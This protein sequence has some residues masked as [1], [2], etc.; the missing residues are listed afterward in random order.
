MVKK[1]TKLS[2]VCIHHVLTQPRTK[3]RNILLVN[4]DQKFESGFS[5]VAPFMLC[6]ISLQRNSFK[7][8]KC[9]FVFVFVEIQSCLKFELLFVHISDIAQKCPKTKTNWISDI[10]RPNICLKT[11]PI[12][13]IS[14][15][16]W[17]LNCLNSVWNLY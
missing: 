8:S 7:Y 10:S 1:T 17:N 3:I 12:V 2:P 9:L 14:D 4:E 15:N 5:I 11:T 16:V 6:L 13:R